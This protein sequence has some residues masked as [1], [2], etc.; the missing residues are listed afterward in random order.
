MAT[1]KTAKKTVQGTAKTVKGQAK[2]LQKQANKTLKGAA[3]VLPGDARKT[4]RFFQFYLYRSAQPHRSLLWIS[5]MHSVKQ[6]RQFEYPMESC[7]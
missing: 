3:K 2:S 7:E 6:N 4:I 1:G 5:R